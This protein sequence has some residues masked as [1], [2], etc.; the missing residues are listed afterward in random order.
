MTEAFWQQ[1]A[2]GA[3]IPEYCIVQ[4]RRRLRRPLRRRAHLAGRASPQRELHGLSRAQGP[5]RHRGADQSRAHGHVP[6]GPGA[7]LGALGAGAWSKKRALDLAVHRARQRLA[8]APER[9]PRGRGVGLR[10]TIRQMPARGHKLTNGRGL[11]ST[12]KRHEARRI[13]ANIT[14]LPEML[15]GPPPIKRGVTRLRRHIPRQSAQC[16]L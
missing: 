12:T 5:Q 15:R 1:H 13:A 8:A 7:L 14:K 2:R 3:F 11:L 4:P 6:H 16:P 10:R 9:L